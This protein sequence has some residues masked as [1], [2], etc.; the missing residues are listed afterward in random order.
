MRVQVRAELVEEIVID[1]VT[2]ADFEGPGFGDVVLGRVRIV[3]HEQLGVLKRRVRVEDVALATAFDEAYRVMSL[4]SKSRALPVS[5][6][7]GMLWSSAASA[8]WLASWLVRHA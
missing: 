6:T 4:S 7:A 3:K 5:R 8:T 2:V 1:R